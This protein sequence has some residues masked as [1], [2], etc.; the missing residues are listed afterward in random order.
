MPPTLDGK[1]MPTPPTVAP[2]GAAPHAT[3]QDAVRTSARKPPAIA[4]IWARLL[5]F[6]ID[7]LVLLVVALGLAEFLV[8]TLSAFGWRSYATSLAIGAT[9][10]VP[11]VYFALFEGSSLKAS[12]GKRLL[13]LRVT[14]MRGAPLDR[15]TAALRAMVAFLLAMPLGAGFL[16]A[17]ANAKHQSAHDRSLKTLVLRKHGDGIL[18]GSLSRWESPIVIVASLVLLLPFVFAAYLAVMSMVAPTIRDYQRA[19]RIADAIASVAPLQSFIEQHI[20]TAKAYP[21]RLDDGL[22]EQTSKAARSIVAYNA[23][24]GVLTVNLG[25]T[26]TG[27]MAVISL[28]PIPSRDGNV[29]WNC[30]AFS[31]PERLLP[32]ACRS[33]RRKH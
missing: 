30:S 9:C 26:E 13:G 22:L 12:P 25:L 16:A 17:I 15:V 21:G 11:I 1:E 33:T 31:I 14:D 10:V 23:A 6:E 27:A 5:A 8:R 3:K 29:Q 32:E 18:S 7:L 24:N 2:A 19:N 28:Y 4:G 20:R